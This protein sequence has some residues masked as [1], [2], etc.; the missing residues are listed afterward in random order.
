[1]RAVAGGCGGDFAAQSCPD[2]CDLIDCSPQAS[3]S[4]GYPRQEY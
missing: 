4:M 2:L 1:M 3:L